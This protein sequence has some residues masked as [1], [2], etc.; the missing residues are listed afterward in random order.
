MKRKNSSKSNLKTSTTSQR[1]GGNS[2]VLSED[3]ESAAAKSRGGARPGTDL[4]RQPH[5]SCRI[6]LE[7]MLV[8]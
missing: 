8:C 4:F 1:E 3:R 7:A 5:P 2:S 6:D